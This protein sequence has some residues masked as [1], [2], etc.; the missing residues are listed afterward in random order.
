MT[1][2]NKIPEKLV[3]IKKGQTGTGI[4][5]ESDGYVSR[6]LTENNKKMIKEAFEARENG[7]WDIPNPFVLDVILQKF[8]IQNANGRIYPEEILKREVEKY[9]KLINE[10]M[11][12]GE[13]Y[14]P[15]VMILCE[16][17]WK[18]LKD[19]TKDDNVLTLNTETNNIEIQ[20]VSRKIE[21]DYD[22]E[23]INLESRN[24][25]ESV[26]PNHGYP[27]YN[28]YNKFS[29]F[30]TAENIFN[31]E[32]KDQAHSFIPK[33]GNWTESG[34]EFFT[35]KGI[36]TPTSRMLRNHPDCKE[37]KKIP[38]D[39]FMKFM[40]IYLSEG[41]YSKTGNDVRI[42]QV[43]PS[44]CSMVED[45]MVELDLKYTIN[46][47][48]NGN[49][50]YIIC[51]PRLHSYVKVLGDCYN[52][53]IPFELKQQSK[54]NLRALY[55][56]FMLG[57]GRIR[58]V[59]RN[60]KTK[61]TD[62]AFS[63]SQQLAFDLNEIQLKIG[64]SGNYHI[65]DRLIDERDIKGENCVDMHFSIRSLT[66]GIY[67][68]DRHLKMKKIPYNGKV[69]CI[70]VPNHTFYVMSNGKCHW[71]KNCNHPAES[72]IDLGRISHN[73]IECHW[74]GNTLVGK[75][76]F[77]L[78]EGFRKYGICSSLGDTC[79]NLILNGYKIGVSSRGIGS[80]K[81]VLG[82]TIVCDDFELLCWDIVATPSTPGSYIGHKENLQQYVESD[83]SKKGKSK[84]N[85]KI[86]RLK[87]ILN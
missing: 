87:S 78:T 16:S 41:D 30:Y 11:A 39:T 25:S 4:L 74:E 23:L 10:R 26:T 28:R 42:Y 62:D 19:V 56:W 9:Q 86:E 20:K 24:I 65:E 3:E 79:A 68:D 38:M 40:G 51:D 60:K 64:Y 82:K 76:E 43:K 12:L 49:H 18:Q 66:K 45:L 17:G 7:E 44:I 32:V 85:E 80:V 31:H 81:T 35:L 61:L 33:Q 73:I 8:G 2:K 59:K 14:T 69:M 63:V 72:T 53:Y 83:E 15:E 84:L 77:N 21:Y 58:G 71:S 70:E 50:T 1:V 37:D 27:I 47:S 48:K 22:G 34:D 13:C 29:G 57:D 52:K 46:I 75:I 55:D 36:E 67:L 54:D 6:D 5:I